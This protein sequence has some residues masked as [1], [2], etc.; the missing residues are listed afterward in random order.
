MSFKTRQW[1]AF[2]R[3]ERAGRS[4]AGSRDNYSEQLRQ[5]LAGLLAASF[6]L[7]NIE[8]EAGYGWST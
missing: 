8:L 1:P 3:Q 5:V 7:A 4:D 6:Q 2:L